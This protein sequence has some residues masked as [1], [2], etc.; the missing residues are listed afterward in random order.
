M[1]IRPL[2]SPSQQHEHFSCSNERSL[3]SV[4]S[5]WETTCKRN[6]SSDLMAGCCL[7]FVQQFCSSHVAR[8]FPSCV[9]TSLCD[10]SDDF[11]TLAQEKVLSITL[12]S[13]LLSPLCFLLSPFSFLL[14]PFS[15]LLSPFSFLLSP[16]SF[17]VLSAGAGS[18][19]S[20]SK[21]RL[22]SPLPDQQRSSSCF[23]VCFVGFPAAHLSF[24]CLRHGG[25]ILRPFQVWQ[26]QSKVVE[27]ELVSQ[28]RSSRRGS[29]REFC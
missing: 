15:F 29:A 3:W 2:S 18:G 4:W 12:P 16:F 8:C 27:S 7:Q 9:V 25:G 21:T 28:L 17:S 6:S 19:R 14:S 1:N 26:V 13:S 24:V 22:S 23:P 5:L 11:S 20:K 10:S